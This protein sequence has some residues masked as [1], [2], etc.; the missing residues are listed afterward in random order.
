[1]AFLSVSKGLRIALPSLSAS[2]HN[3]IKSSDSHEI[4]KPAILGIAIILLLIT[5]TFITI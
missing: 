2:T 5:P 3:D 1:M 4:I